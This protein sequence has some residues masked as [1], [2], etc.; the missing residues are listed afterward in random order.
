MKHSTLAAAVPIQ[1]IPFSVP[2]DFERIRTP[3]SCNGDWPHRVSE[4][5]TSVVLSHW[6]GA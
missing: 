4:S 2:I 3:G 1:E 6:E 5:P